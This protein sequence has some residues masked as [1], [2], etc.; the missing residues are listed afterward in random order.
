MQGQDTTS[1]W[2]KDLCFPNCSALK[3]YVIVGLGNTFP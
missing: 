2:P 3:C 1:D